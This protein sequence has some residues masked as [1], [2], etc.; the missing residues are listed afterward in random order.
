MHYMCTDARPDR[1]VSCAVFAHDEAELMDLQGARANPRTSIGWHPPDDLRATI[2]ATLWL[3]AG[4]IASAAYSYGARLIRPEGLPAPLFV[5]QA[6]IL[7]V[8]LLTPPRRWW[9]FLLVAYGFRVTTNFWLAG[10]PLW[11][12]LLGNLP[13]V[14]EPLVGALLLRRCMPLPPRFASLREVGRYAA[15]VI[16]AS[17]LGAT[18]GAA[19]RLTLGSPYW[20]SWQAW[21]LSDVLAS[22]LL[23]PTILLW[24]RA[25]TDGLRAGSR[26]RAV[27]AALLCVALLLSGFVV[28]GARVEN[29]DTAPALL[30]LVVPL[31]L[32][33]AVRFGPRGLASALSVTTVFAIA[34]VA[35]GLGP[36]VAQ[37]AQANLLVL[38]LFLFAIG[39]PLFFLAALVQEHREARVS[40]QQS[41]ERYRAVV[42]N[43]PDGIVLLFG[44]DLRH[45]FEDGRGLPEPGLS[46]ASVVGKTPSQAFP[47]DV[48]S[49]LTPHYQMALTGEQASFDLRHGNRMYLAH[50][51]PVSHGIEAAGMVVMQDVTEQRRAQALALSEAALRATN[52]Q[53]AELS[54][55]KSD[56]LSTVSHEV[57]TPLGSMRGF[58]EMIRDDTLS[59]AEVYEYA[60]LINAE[61][62]RLGRLV[63]DLLD[64][65]RLESGRVELHL[66]SVD[67]RAIVTEAFEYARPL[68]NGHTFQAALD[69]STPALRG[70]VDKLTQVVSN[71]LSNAVKYSPNGGPVVIGAAVEDPFV[72]LWVRDEGIGIPMAS[73]DAVFDRYAR[74]ELPEHLAIKGTGLGLPIVR[75]IAELHGGR[76]WA[77]SEPGLGSTFHVTLPI[78]GPPAPA[79]VPSVGL[80]A[81]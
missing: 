52:E 51:Q 34:G 6:V 1:V 31:L 63:D 81:P 16:A 49:V 78:D 54:Q 64:L 79:P 15:C 48:A 56:F 75:Q 10:A 43:F 20:P 38:Q 69:P 36:F 18:L 19:A 24:I 22:L 13:S 3:L 37:S 65:D 40:L 7:S 61:A 4:L 27:E 14:I 72:H 9:L 42:S 68:A 77:E 28:F 30:Y 11:F 73:L 58:S 41:E 2:R 66:E 17:M 21:F 47:P 70:D 50:V 23:A 80:A 71:L 57:R 74:V 62:Q 55:A 33:A 76:A 67:L 26:R 29:P 59:Q 12:S 32:W 45:V 25:G 5:P 60:N 8:L 53:L 44:A 35:N 46:G 39:V